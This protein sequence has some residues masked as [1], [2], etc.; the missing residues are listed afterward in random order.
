M[1]GVSNK[2]NIQEIS[3][4]NLD[5]YLDLSIDKIYTRLKRIIKST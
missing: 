5:I 2:E 4:S 1:G 3:L